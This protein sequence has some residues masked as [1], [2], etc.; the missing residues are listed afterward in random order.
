[1]QE[2]TKVEN[3]A[4]LIQDD[5]L[6]PGTNVRLKGS[7][8][9]KGDLAVSKDS[10][11]MPAAIGFLAGIGVTEILVYPNPSISIIVTGNELIKPGQSLQKGQ[12][13]ESNSYSLQAALKQLHIQ[14]VKVYRV[15]DELEKVK[16]VMKDALQE[17]EIV[18]LTGGVSVGEY[19]FVAAAAEENGIE[20]VFHKIKQR[21]GKPLFF[22]KKENKLIFGLPG[23]PASVLTCFYEYVEPALRKM[24]KQK[25]GIQVT[26][27]SLSMPFK[28]ATGLTH[29]LKGFYDGNTV[30]PLHAQESYRLSSFAHANCLIKIE[31]DVTHCDKG[32]LVEIHL[33]PV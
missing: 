12:V 26:K 24:T 6:R 27:A 32:E 4:L 1:M 18:F 17:T 23:N 14:N 21:P 19:D 25:T 3:D 33:L 5:T 13:Y 20:K 16:H 11:L 10:L 30:T 7:E 15:E 31:E 2:K 29:F 9:N 22:G 8:I 28:K